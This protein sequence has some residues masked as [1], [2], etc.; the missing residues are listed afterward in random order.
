MCCLLGHRGWPA[1]RDDVPVEDLVACASHAGTVLAKETGI[2]CMHAVLEC[3]VEDSHPPRSRRD[4]ARPV[5]TGS[6]PS[7]RLVAAALRVT[8]FRS[9][10]PAC[11]QI[12][13]TEHRSLQSGPADIMRKPHGQHESWQLVD[14]NQELTMGK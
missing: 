11:N 1:G 2:G 7:A 4:E 8:E 6:L 13:S 10:S 5:P 14:R 9:R 3:K 12:R